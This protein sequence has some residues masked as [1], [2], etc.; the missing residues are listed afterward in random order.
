MI[1]AAVF[2]RF[3]EFGFWEILAVSLAYTLQIYCDF[4]GYSDMSRGIAAM[5]G[6]STMRNFR[7]PYLAAGPQPCFI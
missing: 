1:T 7:Q 6:F 5:L 4:A 2:P 3:E